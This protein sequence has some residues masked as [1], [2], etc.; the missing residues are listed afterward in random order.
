MKKRKTLFRFGLVRKNSDE[1][2]P[3]ASSIS[4]EETS[5]KQQSNIYG[6][7]ANFFI[8]IF[9]NTLCMLY[10][11]AYSTGRN[12]AGSCEIKKICTK[13]EVWGFF[14]F[15]AQVMTVCHFFNL[16]C[17]LVTVT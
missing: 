12:E 1:F 6:L 2:F 5:E 13:T 15:A 9:K 10:R 17:Q 16:L 4:L 3:G 7:T 11:T 14:C 8:F